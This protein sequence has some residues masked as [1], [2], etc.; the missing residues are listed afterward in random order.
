MLVLVTLRKVSDHLADGVVSACTKGSRPTKR[1][2]ISSSTLASCDSFGERGQPTH[3]AH[4][5]PPGVCGPWPLLAVWDPRF[6]QAHRSP[7]TRN[8]RLVPPALC[9]PWPPRSVGPA[10]F[11]GSSPTNN[12]PSVSPAVCG[13]WPPLAVWDRD[14]LGSPPTLLPSVA[15]QSTR[16]FSCHFA[17]S[18]ALKATQT[19]ASAQ[20][21]SHS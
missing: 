7:P 16:Y 10:V 5:A 20:W 3:N 1:E 8:S 2:G 19:S 12:T 18:G 21:A 6:S 9:G 15:S 11:S 13:S 4:T 14:F 17:A